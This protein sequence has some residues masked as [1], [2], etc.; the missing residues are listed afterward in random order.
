M[1]KKGTPV[2]HCEPL[3]DRYYCDV[4]GDLLMDLKKGGAMLYSPWKNCWLFVCIVMIVSTLSFCL[5]FGIHKAKLCGVKHYEGKVEL[6]ETELT[7]K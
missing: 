6:T 5:S 2:V 1:L 4:K 7:A 3:T